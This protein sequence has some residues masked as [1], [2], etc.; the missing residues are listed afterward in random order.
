MR[1]DK[2]GILTVV[3][4]TAVCLPLPLRAQN[5]FVA[6]GTDYLA[7]GPGIS[8]DLS[9]QRFP[10]NTQF[11]GNP[12]PNFQCCIDTVIQRQQ[13][14]VIGGAQIPVQITYLSLCSLD[15]TG[16]TRPCYPLL[17]NNGFHYVIYVTLDPAQLPNDTG[18]ATING[19][20]AGGAFTITYALYYMVRF[21]PTDGGPDI[22]P[23]KNATTL[24]TAAPWTPNT[25]PFIYTVTAPYPA[26]Q[27]NV[28]TNLPAPDVE[29][30]DFFLTNYERF[31][32][33]SGNFVM[34]DGP[35]CQSPSGTAAV[36]P[37]AL[38]WICS[39]PPPAK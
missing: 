8:L 27:A 28:H 11:Q 4:L 3:V 12:N 18:L 37:K 34:Q 15:P 29:A 23:V 7:T 10:V 9:A 22:A 31:T 24:Q 39:T 32:T 6:A 25:P 35:A 14:A 36:P 16:Q 21:T 1:F 30:V 26:Q 13:D 20:A 17:N 2:S 38:W 5:N 33:S 19:N